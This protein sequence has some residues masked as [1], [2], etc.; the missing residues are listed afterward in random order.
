MREFDIPG[1]TVLISGITCLLLALQWGGIVYPWNSGA[2]VALLVISGALLLLFV[3]MQWKSRDS[4]LVPFRILLERNV[5]CTMLYHV[6]M[7]AGITI[8]EYYVRGSS[9]AFLQSRPC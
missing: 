8:Y 9:A 4:A 5:C 6:L 7:G 2:I 1:A 3:P